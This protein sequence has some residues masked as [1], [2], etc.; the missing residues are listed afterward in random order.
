M[1]YER[2]ERP[3]LHTLRYGGIPSKH[4]MPSG[5]KRLNLFRCVYFL[6]SGPLDTGRFTCRITDIRTYRLNIAWISLDN[7]KRRSRL[8]QFVGIF[9]K[10]RSANCMIP[11]QNSDLVA[12]DLNHLSRP[13]R[14]VNRSL[15]RLPN[16]QVAHVFKTLA[17]SRHP[18]IKRLANLLMAMKTIERQ[19]VWMTISFFSFQ[20]LPVDFNVDSNGFQCLSMTLI[21][22]AFNTF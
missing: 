7:I 12:Q 13:L 11:E 3:E 19:C 17:A 1:H 6:S 2:S 20:W 22:I 15:K 18:E 21:S 14:I 8:F 4:R 9:R 5:K 10:S 16:F